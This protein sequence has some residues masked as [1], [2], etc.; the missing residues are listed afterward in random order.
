MNTQERIEVMVKLGKYIKKNEEEWKWVK[1]RAYRENPWFIPEFIDTA[2]SNIAYGFL[3]KSKLEKWVKQYNINENKTA[4]AIGVVMAG[5]I[6]LVGFHDLLAVFISGNKALIK[7]SSKDEVLIKHVVRKMCEWNDEVASLI[8]FADML[9]GC[10]AY[11]ATGSNNSGRYF[12][13]YFSKY[14]HIIRKNKTSVAVLTGDESRE[15][16]HFLADDIQLYFGSGCRNITKLYVPEGYDFLRLLDALKKYDYLIDFHKYKHNFDYQLA[17][18]IMNNKAYMNNGSI[19][20]TENESVFSPI[21]RVNYEYYS[22]KNKLIENLQNNESIQCIVGQKFIPFGAVQK[23]SL[24]DYADG[25]DT[26]K[27]L[28]QL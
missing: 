13:Y 26:M 19:I 17:L 5:N 18:L 10:D 25:V 28:T 24:N 6:P 4:K 3:E 22:D 11:I 27:F 20:L 21:S 16:I 9:K 15:E 2:S 14:P 7:P 8:F 12:E 1:E 23:P